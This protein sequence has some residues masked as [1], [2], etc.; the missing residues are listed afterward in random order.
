MGSSTECALLMMLRSWGH[1]YGDVRKERDAD[2]LKVPPSG[3]GAGS[4][5]LSTFAWQAGYG[6]RAGP[7][8]RSGASGTSWETCAR[9]GV[10]TAGGSRG[11]AAGRTPES[12]CSTQK[13]RRM[14]LIGA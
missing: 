3:E 5:T 8:K 2:M 9:R 13:V 4:G 14:C 7:H 6:A 11:C 10:R 12:A 1:E